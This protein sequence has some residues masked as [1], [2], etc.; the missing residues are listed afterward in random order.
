MRKLVLFIHATL[1]GF[2]AGPNGEMNW[3][4]IDDEIFDYAGSR[5]DNADTGLYGRVTYE[6]MDAYWPTAGD[7]P[8][9]SKHDIQHAEWYNRV[10]KVII[11]KTMR[12]QDSDKRKVISDNIPARVT[13]LKQQEGKEIVMFGSP[14]TAHTLMQHNLIDEYWLFVNPLLLGQGMPLFKDLKERIN[15]KLIEAR[16]FTSGVV[17]LHYEKE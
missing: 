14:G 13:A 16:A 4:H 1:D 5:T 8:D 3:I 17:C 6:M 11:S 10:D 15:L 12:G 9:A 2:A 7:N